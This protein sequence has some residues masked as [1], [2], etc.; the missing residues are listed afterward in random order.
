MDKQL[1]KLRKAL[2]LTQQEFA[3]KIGTGRNNIAKYETGVNEPSNAVISLI[4]KELHVNE[5][6]L[7]TGEGDMFIKIDEDDRYSL[8]L[9][10]LSMSEN[11]FV[12]NAINTLAETEPEKLK[13]VED[14]MKKFLG[15]K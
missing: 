8:N 15:I 2:G 4:C 11:E 5:V 14:F 13:I 6:W 12:I 10:K 9:G 1:K 7:R 3:D